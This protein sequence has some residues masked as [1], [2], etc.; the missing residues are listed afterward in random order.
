MVREV[1]SLVIGFPTCRR[2]YCGCAG[3]SVAGKISLGVMKTLISFAAV[4]YTGCVRD[5]QH[6][7]A[8]RGDVSP[9]SL[10][11]SEARRV[12]RSWTVQGEVCFINGV[13]GVQEH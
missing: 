13:E 7:S 11:S 4:K 5:R 2:F 8:P 10:T 12:P 9:M 1:V 6:S 3:S